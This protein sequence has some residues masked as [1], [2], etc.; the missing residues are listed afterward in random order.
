MA[1]QLFPAPGQTSFTFDGLQPFLGTCYR[2]DGLTMEK[3]SLKCVFHGGTF[4]TVSRDH[5]THFTGQTTQALTKTHK[6]LTAVTVII[7]L[8]HQ[9]RTAE[10]R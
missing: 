8:N 9:A 5:G 2:S 7:I 10:Q 6:L 4:A 3:H 1:T